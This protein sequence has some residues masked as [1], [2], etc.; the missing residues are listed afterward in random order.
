LVGLTFFLNKK[1]NNIK[2]MI[3]KTNSKEN[4]IC[5]NK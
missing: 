3:T 5:F 2:I 4:I 1:Y